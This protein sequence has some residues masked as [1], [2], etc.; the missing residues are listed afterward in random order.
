MCT[1]NPSY[2]PAY[3]HPAPLRYMYWR[4]EAN[5]YN[6]NSLLLNEVSEL[7]AQGCLNGDF[8]VGASL[9]LDDVY[10]MMKLVS[11]VKSRGDPAPFWAQF[12]GANEDK[13]ALNMAFLSLLGH[14]MYHEESELSGK[15]ML[16]LI[17]GKTRGD[18][19]FNSKI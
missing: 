6:M 18:L 19:I 4:E 1:L 2:L 17:I 9:S 12:Q 5:S 7:S 15:I 11:E 14:T 10:S 13:V 3:L 16:S 8:D